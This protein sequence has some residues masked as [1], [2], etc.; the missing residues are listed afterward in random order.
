MVIIG[1]VVSTHRNLY[2]H[3]TCPSYR[4]CW[5]PG[6][7]PLRNREGGGGVREDEGGWG[8][9]SAERRRWRD[10]EAGHDHLSEPEAEVTG[11]TKNHTPSTL[12]PVQLHVSY[13]PPY[14]QECGFSSS[15]W[16]QPLARIDG[17]VRPPRLFTSV[18]PRTY[19][20]LYM[21]W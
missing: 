5:R 18:V 17:H 21:T 2:R 13:Q 10:G 20:P 1:P 14:E 19:P 6:F 11:K 9:M 7:S 12:F 4:N 8:G 3:A 16:P 15:Q